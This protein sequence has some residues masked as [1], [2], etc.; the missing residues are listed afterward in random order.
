MYCTCS[1]VRN[2]KPPILRTEKPNSKQEL[3]LNIPGRQGYLLF[4]VSFFPLSDASQLRSTSDK[5]TAHDRGE[6]AQKIKKTS[7]FL[8]EYLVKLKFLVA[9]HKFFIVLVKH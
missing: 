1:G 4:Q 2:G 6:Y 7:P 9:C 5:I 3:I 8:A